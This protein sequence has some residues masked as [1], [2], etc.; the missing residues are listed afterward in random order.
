MLNETNNELQVSVKL[1]VRNENTSKRFNPQSKCVALYSPPQN[2]VL[3]VEGE[4][5][6]LSAQIDALKGELLNKSTEL[7]EK[8]HQY[9]KLQ[10]QLSEA[11]QKHSK[12]LENAGIQLAQLEAQVI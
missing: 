4:K 12:D 5:A 11:G 6:G 1:L 2:K 10:L 9:D 8:E 7:E 3:C